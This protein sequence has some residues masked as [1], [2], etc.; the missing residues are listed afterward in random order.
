M[1]L[2]AFY[3]LKPFLRL[4]GQDPKALKEASRISKELLCLMPL[5]RAAE[6]FPLMRFQCKSKVLRDMFGSISNSEIA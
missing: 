5:A 2:L 3:Y 6:P 1:S 4:R